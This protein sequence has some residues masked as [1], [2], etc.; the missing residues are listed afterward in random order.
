MSADDQIEID[1]EFFDELSVRVDQR[2]GETRNPQAVFRA[3]EQLAENLRE[4]GWAPEEGGEPVSA[5][6]CPDCEGG[7]PEPADAANDECDGRCPWCGRGFSTLQGV[8]Q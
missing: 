5:Y 1:E 3:V 4:A 8:D 7:F 2:E 6:V